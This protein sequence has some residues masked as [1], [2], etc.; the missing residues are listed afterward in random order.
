MK[1]RD[2]FLVIMLSIIIG[3]CGWYLK[4]FNLIPPGVFWKN[5]FTE[6]IP[7]VLLA[8]IAP[9]FLGKG[10]A[11]RGALIL[12]AIITTVCAMFGTMVIDVYL[13]FKDF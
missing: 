13:V 9:I 12:I 2:V 4:L 3:I 7:T 6:M 5:A 8:L 1:I 10:W 11:E